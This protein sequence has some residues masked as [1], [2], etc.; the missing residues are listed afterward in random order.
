MKTLDARELPETGAEP[1]GL[2]QY[3]NLKLELAALIRGV[4]QLFHEARDDRREHQARR[5]L[6]RLAEDQ[7][8]LVVVGQFKRGKSSLM[9]AVIG[10]DR[11]PTGVL[12]L[13]SVVTTVR[14]GDRECVHVQTR[15]SSLLCEIPL[16]QLPEYVTEKGNP[17][18][19]KQVLLAMVRLPAE[20]LRLGF[21]FIDTPGIGSAIV[22]NTAT[23]HGFLPEADAVIFVTGFE[24]A[25]NEGEL[26][27]LRTV[28]R[29]VSKIFFVV[30]KRDLV[31]A[32]E[33]E[34]VLASIRETISAQLGDSAPRLFAISAREGLE[35]KLTGNPE[36][37]AQSGLPEFESALTRFL[38]TERAHVSLLRT[39]ERIA[40]L[41]TPEHVEIRA[42]AIRAGLGSEAVRTMKHEWDRRIRQIETACRQ[43]AEALCYRVRSELPFRFHNAIEQHC[44]DVHE[45]LRAQVDSLLLQQGAHDLQELADRAQNVATDRL[46][47]WLEARR[48]EFVEA[49]WSLAAEGVERLERLHGEALGLAAELLR[50]PQAATVSWSINRDEAVF[51]WRAAAPFE[52]RPRYAWELELFSME[53]LRRRV[54]R[55]YYRT[56]E[57]AAG[58]Y[59]DQVTQAV[60]EAGGEWAGE[61]GSEVCSA[62]ERLRSQVAAAV[63]GRS[64][65]VISGRAGEL[66]TRLDN[67]RQELAKGGQAEGVTLPN[68]PTGEQRIIRSCFVC[69]RMAAAMFDFFSKRQYELAMNEA[70]Q[71]A[72]TANGGFCPLHTWQ[73]EHIASPHGVCLAYGPLLAAVARHLRSIATSASSS[74]SM[75]DRVDDLYPSPAR[76]PACQ[77]A[78]EAEKTAVEDLHRDHAVGEFGLCLAHLSAMLGKESDVETARALM[79]EQ[80]GTLERISQDMQTYALKHD[81][82]RRELASDAEWIAYLAGL[83]LLVGN[84]KLAAA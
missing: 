29:H 47:R 36:M 63:E 23:T 57:A 67:M 74:R 19:R 44:A 60:A 32:E 38:T 62:L 16:A 61:L 69:E 84:R 31:S 65:S 30:N 33:S 45:S 51:S 5:L 76:C 26:A 41:L 40:A 78:S 13:T 14:H 77:R 80:A 39:T 64:L 56:L 34:T 43:T 81:A 1:A 53:W 73:Y 54:Q 10:L 75:R 4:M 11:L 66:L 12:P 25:M 37:L 52:W 28:A 46:R 20:I 55:D 50:V 18:N 21:H 82:V 79:F 71:R 35:A 7:F 59:R 17:G 68:V 9:N 3:L 83:S 70:R 72:H 8:N 24:S 22:A 48:P 49:L 42:S 27:F 58:A 15:E 6:S 2:E